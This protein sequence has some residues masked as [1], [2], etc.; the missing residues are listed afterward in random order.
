MVASPPLP[1]SARSH[2]HTIADA[3]DDF[4][5]QFRAITQRAR[6][7][8]EA[9]NWG[10]GQS[11]AK[12]RLTLY[13]TRVDEVEAATRVA[14]TDRL[15]DKTLWSAIRA[16]YS[17][18]IGNRRDAE[19]AETFFNSITRRIFATVGVDPAIEFVTTD[20]DAPP[21]PSTPPTQV[22]ERTGSLSD[23]FDR[24]LTAHAHEASYAHRKRDADAL[25]AIVSERLR[26]HGLT[27]PIDRVELA[28]SVFYRGMGAYLVG[29]VEAGAKTRPLAIA[30]HHAPEGICVDAVLVTEDDVS[31][32]FSFA[33]SYFRVETPHPHALVQF[34]HRILPRKR[35]AE[36][37]IAIGYNKHGKTELYRDLLRHFSNTDDQFTRAP[38]QRGM[39]MIVFTMPSYDMVFKVMKDRFDYPKT[40]TKRTVKQ[41]YD[42]VF[43]HDRAGRL[44]D[45]QQFEHL[46]LSRHLFSDALLD[47][48][49]DVAGDTVR[50]TPN[51]VVID[52][53][54]VE[55]R[56]TP[57]D[58]YLRTQPSEQ[59][60]AALLEYGHAIKDLARSNIFPGD[61]LLK[62][63]GVTRHG[64]VV[65]YDY[66][67]LCFLTD[68]EFRAKPAP[69]THAEEMAQD[70]WFYVGPDDVFPEEFRAV[71]GLDDAL[72]DTLEA[73]HGDLFAPD[74]W[75]RTQTR[76][77]AGEIIPILP[78][79][80]A[81]RLPDRR[82]ATS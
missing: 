46:R 58:V 47:E 14:L 24:I 64:R 41:R 54:Y 9:R 63:F 65:F 3:F 25:A 48:L 12:A 70:A 18:R 39:V 76:I 15:H 23:L 7:R 69:R 74:F 67:E 28:R 6:L 10:G 33:R 29:C 35:I 34:L 27:A 31:I 2:A 78:Y 72:M 45:A 53:A 17:S 68:C 8:F 59:A 77:E 66:D 13:R 32:L 43:Q 81:L 11:D 49:T 4:Q 40:A 30:L 57:L 16:A 75:Q 71:L 61:L 52:H 22:F 44:V 80:A 62:N 20:I 5:E 1:A 51:R 50:T 82:P 79:P 21:P 38:G 26:Q 19:L 56:V 36:L 55:R 73:H 37:Y 60:T 42:L